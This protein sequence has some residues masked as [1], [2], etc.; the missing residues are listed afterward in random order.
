MINSIRCDSDNRYSTVQSAVC[1]QYATRFY[2]SFSYE[3]EDYEGYEDFEDNGVNL[4]E[5]GVV[6]ATYYIENIACL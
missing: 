4:F 1:L 2:Y 6:V 3:Y 5:R